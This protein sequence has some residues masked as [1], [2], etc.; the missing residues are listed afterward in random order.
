MERQKVGRLKEKVTKE[1]RKGS[2]YLYMNLDLMCG[3][4]LFD[5]NA[6]VLL[7]PL[8]ALPTGPLVQVNLRHNGF[9][10]IDKCK[11]TG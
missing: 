7:C 10:A 3:I 8:S 11:K 1:D 9:V 2:F 4:L 6:F 5:Y